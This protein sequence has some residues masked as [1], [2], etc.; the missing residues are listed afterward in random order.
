MATTKALAIKTLCHSLDYTNWLNV[1]CFAANHAL[2]G[3][4]I[5]YRILKK[6]KIGCLMSLRLCKYLKQNMVVKN[7]ILGHVYVNKVIVCHW[8]H[9]YN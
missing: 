2:N 5:S 7:T 6:K 9:D 1:N 3:F 8:I 4:I